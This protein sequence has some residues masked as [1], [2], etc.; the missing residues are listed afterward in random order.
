MTLD[1]PIELSTKLGLTPE[2]IR[3]DLA[4]GLYADKTVS[5]GKAAKLANMNHRGFQQLLSDLRIPIHYD[6]SDLKE[7][8]LVLRELG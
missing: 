3:R 5:L 2:K 8:L 7:D 1:V 6:V 4:I